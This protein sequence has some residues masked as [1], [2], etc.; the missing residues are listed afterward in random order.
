MFFL[1]L[2]SYIQSVSKSWLQLYLQ[3]TPEPDHFCPLPLLPPSDSRPASSLASSLLPWLPLWPHES[4]RAI[5][6]CALSLSDKKTPFPQ[7]SKPETRVPSETSLPLSR[8]RSGFCC[9]FSLFS[10][11]SG[12]KLSSHWSHIG[13]LAD[14]RSP[15]KPCS[16]SLNLSVD[17]G[18]LPWLT[19]SMLTPLAGSRP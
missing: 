10:Q 12:S 6:P 9:G 4:A 5:S 8:S 18:P 1:S 7:L 15:H 16:L 13:L 14:P 2:T 19:P 17:R 11:L 3:N